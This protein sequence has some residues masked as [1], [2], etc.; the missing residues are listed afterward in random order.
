MLINNISVFVNDGLLDC[1]TICILKCNKS[2]ISF[3]GIHI[4]FAFDLYSNHELTIAKSTAW[5]MRRSGHFFDL[6]GY[7]GLDA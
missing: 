7:S 2:N 1:F 5:K 6:R 4:F 3:S